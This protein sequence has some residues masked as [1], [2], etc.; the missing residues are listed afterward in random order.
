MAGLD[1]D[2]DAEP[3]GRFDARVGNGIA[4][5][6]RSPARRGLDSARRTA[7]ATTA[8]ATVSSASFNA[9][10]RRS[11][12]RRGIPTRTCRQRR[13]RSRAAV[14]AELA[15]WCAFQQHV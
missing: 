1:A 5:A 14:R 12:R 3:G 10:P 11:C 13:A 7:G 9:R 6:A 15:G 4:G 2:D 8:S